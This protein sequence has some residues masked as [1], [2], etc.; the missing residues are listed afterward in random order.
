MYIYIYI[1]IYRERERE[2]RLAKATRYMHLV[3]PRKASEPVPETSAC[4]TFVTLPVHLYQCITIISI[5][6]HYII[7]TD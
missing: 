2:M 7:H 3:L 5:P 1:Y 6:V 4:L